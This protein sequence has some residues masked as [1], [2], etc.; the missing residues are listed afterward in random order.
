MLSVTVN[1]CGFISCILMEA[2]NNCLSGRIAV[3]GGA[4]NLN[5]FV[6]MPLFLRSVRFA[7]HPMRH[8]SA[9]PSQTIRMLP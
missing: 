6:Y 5:T 9:L 7:L 4:R 8:Y 1:Y 3:F 2:L